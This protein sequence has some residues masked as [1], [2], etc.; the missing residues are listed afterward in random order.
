MLQRLSGFAAFKYARQLALHYRDDDLAAMSAQISYYLILA[1][2]P[3]LFFLI[4]LLSFTTLPNRLLI[5]NFNAILP[6]ETALLVK[7]MLTETVQAKSGAMLVLSMLASLWAASRGMSAI[8]RGLNHS[9]GVKESRR[10]VR[11][12]M[13]AL[14]STVG[15]SVM[16]LISFIMIVLGRI[17]GSTIFGYMGAK[18]LFYSIWSFL[19]YGITFGLLLT[20]F[21]LIY[22]YLPNRKLTGNHVLAG[23]I[24]TTVG[25]IGASLLF[26][27][28]VNNFGSYATVYGSL[29]GMFALIFWLYISTLIFL[30]GGAIN[31]ICSDRDDAI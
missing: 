22:R 18:S 28:Y 20:T 31:A 21:Y 29:G 23:T 2:F 11:L 3:F 17:I 10:F 19:R 8:I 12:N 7:T 6:Q 30:L 14:L 9:Y 27:F 25:W 5:A 13:V 26:S 15:L 4:N 24:F 16:V 1:F